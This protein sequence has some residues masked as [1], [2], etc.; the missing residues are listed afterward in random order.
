MAKRLVWWLMAGSTVAL[1]SCSVA[2]GEEGSSSGSTST[3]SSGDQLLI[4]PIQVCNDTGGGCAQVEFFQAVV[5][6]AWAQAGIQVTFLPLNQLNDSSY[7]DVTDSEF[8]DLSF[9][10]SAGSFGRHPSSTRDSGPINLWFVD[11]INGSTS[12]SVQYGNAWV[13]ANGVLISDDALTFGTSGRIDVVAHEIG[14]N[15]GLRHSTLGAGGA[16]NLMSAGSVRAIPS[17]VDDIFPDGAQLSQLTDAQVDRAR[18]SGLLTTAAGA[19]SIIAASPDSS[20]DSAVAAGGVPKLQ[21]DRIGVESPNAHP[22]QPLPLELTKAVTA[23][24]VTA[25][26]TV[27][28]PGVSASIWL[29]LGILGLWRVRQRS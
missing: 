24:G 29:G 21:A 1:A 19:A 13:G 5:A 15:L 6:K 8:S 7:L 23:D 12:G 16:N 28:E 27:P 22:P 10:G 26:V 9:S 18:S 4:Q 2:S 25:S 20:P 3:S 14:H 11:T 17:T